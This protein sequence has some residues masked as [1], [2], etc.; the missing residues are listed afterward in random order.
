MDVVAKIANRIIELCK[1]KGITINKL[2]DLSG[3]T[4]STID[5]IVSGKSRNPQVVTL[6]KICEGLNI[7][8]SEFFFEAT[9][10]N[11][12]KIDELPIAAQKELDLFK[13]FLCYKYGIK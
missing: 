12:S 1:E 8:L 13:E 4:Q 11:T 2:A 7:S 10:P 5:S 9:E 3:L 6:Y